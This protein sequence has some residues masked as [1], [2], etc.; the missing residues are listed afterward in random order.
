MPKLSR[1]ALALPALKDARPSHQNKIPFKLSTPSVPPLIFHPD[2]SKSFFK[3]RAER[4]FPSVLDGEQLA[5][6]QDG[7]FY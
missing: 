4:E 3:S 5:L 7:M 1:N 2:D 6:P